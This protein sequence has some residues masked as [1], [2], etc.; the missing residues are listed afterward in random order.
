MMELFLPDECLNTDIL[1]A[2][3]RDTWANCQFTRALY[4]SL[5][6]AIIIVIIIALAFYFEFGYRWHLL[7]GGA[8]IIGISVFVIPSALKWM[9]GRS[10]DTLVVEQKALMSKDEKYKEWKNF[11]EY[12]RAQQ[13]ELIQKQMAEA[14]T[15]QARAQQGIAVAQLGN[16]AIGVANLFK[17]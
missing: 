10:Y 14:Q 15:S 1:L 17:K 12:K 5:I 6:F 8:A 7:I 4:S 3:D 2:P 13:A 11:V 9:H 16:T